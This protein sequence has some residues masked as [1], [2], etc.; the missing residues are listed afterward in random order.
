MFGMTFGGLGKRWLSPKSILD[1]M[2]RKQG[3]DS[4]VGE[5]RPVF[6]TG[7]GIT[8]KEDLDE[9]NDLRDW[10]NVFKP[11]SKTRLHG[12]PNS[13]T[14][15]MVLEIPKRER[16]QTCPSKY[17]EVDDLVGCAV[18]AMPQNWF[19]P[20][21]R[22]RDWELFE[23]DTDTDEDYES[24]SDHIYGYDSRPAPASTPSSD[25]SS[26][27]ESDGRAQNRGLLEGGNGPSPIDSLR[28]IN[29]ELQ[30][31]GTQI[32]PQHAVMK[33]RKRYQHCVE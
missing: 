1:E 13:T 20:Q 5:R 32:F 8:I 23:A 14:L 33:Q 24:D 30:N 21:E 9:I 26:S 11:F 7:T 27:D 4:P 22:R 3:D 10:V 19:H 12:Y 16:S 6:L 17:S 2:L 28:S 31:F 15:C 25:S 29:L 18:G